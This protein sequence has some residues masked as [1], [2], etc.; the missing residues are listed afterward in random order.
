M[1]KSLL[2]AIV[3]L[4]ALAPLAA[5]AAKP[6][7]YSIYC[8]ATL[9]SDQGK[10][11]QLTSTSG[12]SES[13]STQIDL[14][15]YAINAS[16]AR[17]QMTY[18]DIAA[19]ALSFNVNLTKKDHPESPLSAFSANSTTQLSSA[20]NLNFSYQGSNISSVHYSCGAQDAGPT[21]QE[22]ADAINSDPCRKAVEDAIIAVAKND[23]KYLAGF[24]YDPNACKIAAP[25][26]FQGV[27]LPATN[28]NP[29]REVPEAT[30]YSTLVD[31]Q[32]NNPLPGSGMS[33]SALVLSGTCT[34]TTIWPNRMPVMY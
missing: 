16:F 3:I 15:D 27:S 1:K 32:P 21:A 2:N 5:S 24:G 6:P 33:Y 11:T 31:C 28:K 10:K 17:K 25:G 20:A 34:P 29:S 23:I 26:Q 22:L 8:Q 7:R 18:I 9:T 19:Y 12:A 14:G 4:G 13:P 30:H